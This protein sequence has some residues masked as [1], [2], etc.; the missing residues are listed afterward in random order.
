MIVLFYVLT[1]LAQAVARRSP[2]ALVLLVLGVRVFFGPAIVEAFA[3]SS[4]YDVLKP[5]LVDSVEHVSYMALGAWYGLRAAGPAGRW[6]ERL[7]PA[8]LA[9]GSAMWIARVERYV[10]VSSPHLDRVFEFAGMGLLILGWVGLFRLAERLG[11][12]PPALLARLAGLSYGAYL[13]HPLVIFGVRKSIGWLGI[14]AWWDFLPFVAVVYTLVLGATLALVL[15]MSKT[16]AL[17]RLV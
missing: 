9:L 17:R 14:G 2:E 10:D 15:G 4:H 16:P 5:F 6:V 11:Y 3:G 12:G 13:A 8:S 7:W 1:P